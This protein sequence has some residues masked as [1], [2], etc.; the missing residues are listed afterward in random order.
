MDWDSTP[1]LLPLSRPTT[2]NIVTSDVNT[3]RGLHSPDAVARMLKDPAASH[4][5]GGFYFRPRNQGS[6]IFQDQTFL[7]QHA[8]VMMAGY[9]SFGGSSETSKWTGRS[10]PFYQYLT[11]GIL[12]NKLLVDEFGG[13]GHPVQGQRESTVSPFYD[14][15]IHPREKCTTII[16]W[17]IMRHYPHCYLPLSWNE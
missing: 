7:I 8:S 9:H 6:E 4:F 13:Y 5:P 1:L 11:R 15:K 17:N 3:V 12:V 2:E 10:P 14:L 16:L